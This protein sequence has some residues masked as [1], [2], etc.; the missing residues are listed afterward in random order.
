MYVTEGAKLYLRGWVIFTLIFTICF[1]PLGCAIFSKTVIRQL[2]GKESLPS[3]EGLNNSHK[4]SVYEEK[5]TKQKNG[6]VAERGEQVP[7]TAVR[8]V[9]EVTPSVPIGKSYLTLS[10]GTLSRRDYIRSKFPGKKV[11]FPDEL[12]FI[13]KKPEYRLGPDDVVSI[14]VWENPDL[15]TTV[16][17]R[18]DG[19]ISFPL[20]GNIK[21]GGLT[22]P[23]LEDLL[24]EGLMRFMESPQVTINPKE[25]NSQRIFVV[26][27]VRR[28]V[29]YQGLLPILSRQGGNMLLEALADTEFFPD[30]DLAAAYI[31]R[32]DF[33]IPVNIKA[34]MEGDLS[35][36]VR[37]E[38]G[39]QIVVPGPM[40]EVAI[41]GEVQ[42]VDRYK[43]KMDTTLVDALSMAKGIKNATADIYMAYVARNKQIFPVNL[44]ELL[45]HR[46]ISQNMLLE[47]GDIIYIPNIEEKKYYVLGEVNKP[48]VI[49]F[50]HPVDVVEAIAQGGGFLTSA[51]RRQVVV[52][53]GDLR[54]PQIFEIN[55]LAMLDGKS[56]EKFILQRGDIV[57]VPRTLIADWTIFITQVIPTAVAV[58]LLQQV[59]KPY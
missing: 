35:Q 12:Q 6:K 40:K 43:V 27:Q 14:S 15:N 29:Y 38:A 46:D 24:R 13:E 26:G 31:S 45:D 50:K 39:D 41:L 10:A 25:M 9:R 2:D 7:E 21:A 37:L 28:A 57:Y 17:V 16:I 42:A 48:G 36:N 22:I 4:D 34:L 30:A 59:V 32:R 54:N 58:Y 8:A 49:S 1:F 55:L 11:V 33:I 44:K 53:R 3:A 20:V 5:E 19:M 23:E 18:K 51:Q 47:D 52:V 56:F